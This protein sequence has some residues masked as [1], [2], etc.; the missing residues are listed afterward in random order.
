M[1]RPTTRTATPARGNGAPTILRFG[2]HELDAAL[3]ELR[4]GGKRVPV[5]PKPLALLLYLARHRDRL[6]TREELVAHLWPDTVLGDDALFHALKMARAAVGDRGRHQSVIETVRG[7]GFRFVAPVAGSP[8][9]SLRR[10]VPRGRAGKGEA[11]LPLLGRDALLARVRA[12]LVETSRGRGRFLLLS[13]ESGVGKTRMLDAVADAAREHGVR[14]ARGGCREAGGPAF[15]PWSQALES[16]FTA[17]SDAE[18]G[19]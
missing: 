1:H 18:L 14:L 2:E 4:R 17:T 8:P 12:A 5:Q 19:R 13:G 3:F 16:L 9:G 15:A 11:A 6:V 7:V 10:S